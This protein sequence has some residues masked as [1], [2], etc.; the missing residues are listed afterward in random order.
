MPI[1]SRLDSIPEGR[2]TRQPI[3]ADAIAEHLVFGEFAESLGTLIIA[4]R[5]LGTKN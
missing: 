1:G 2:I 4:A 3:G 5:A